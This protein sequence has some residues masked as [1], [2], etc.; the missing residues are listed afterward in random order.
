MRFSEEVLLLREEMRRVLEFLEWHEKWWNE[1]ELRRTGLHAPVAEGV[2]AYARKQAHYRRALHNKF[3]HMWRQS[4][5][6]CALGIGADNEILNFDVAVNYEFAAISEIDEVPVPG[7]DNTAYPAPEPL[8]DHDPLPR[9]THQ[10]DGAP[11][12]P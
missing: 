4:A 11:P 6:F 12:P 8:S 5:E 2:L 1:Q 3:N 7:P 10:L 9:W